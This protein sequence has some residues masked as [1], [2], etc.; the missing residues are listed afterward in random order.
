MLPTISIIG[1]PNVGKS[2]FFNALTKTRDALVA[3]ESGLTRDRKFGR[4]SVGDRDY[5]V[6]DTGGI[7]I[8]DDVIVSHITQQALLAIEESDAIFFVVDGR[9]GLTPV[10]EKL[11]QQIRKF[12]IPVYLVIN[13]SEGIQAEIISAEFLGLGLETYTISA[14]HRSGIYELME[15]VL[16][17]FPDSE[18]IEIDK[19]NRI[20]VAILGRPNVGKSTLVN[21]ILGYE[22]VIAFD[23][24]GTTRDSIFIPFEREGKSY[25]L[26]DTAGVRRR[27]KVHETIEKFSVI[28]A[29]QAIESANV[30]VMLLDANE[31]MTDQDANL[32]G[33][34]LDSGRA[35]IIAVNKWD[36]LDAS[37]REQVRYNL[38]RKLHFIDFATTHFIS[39]LHGKGIQTLFKSI[40]SA[41][42]AAN[43]ETSTSKLNY[44]L[45]AAISKHEPPIV[46]GRRIKL[47]YIHQAGTNPPLFIIHGNQVSSLSGTYKRYLINVLREQLQLKGTPIHLSFKQGDNPF[48]GRKTSLTPRQR[49]KKVRLM[50]HVK[51]K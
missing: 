23:K 33:N 20:K 37:K 39:A 24:P 15:P 10:D 28:K 30:V 6:I 45:E 29:L 38:N 26:I 16:A 42:L 17:S 35:L 2:T 5:W 51:K 3:D 9:A 8:D 7:G 31:G 21:R 44:I 40:N 49:K 11:A 36:D 43:K 32:L 50:K 18:K 14:A 12:N 47:R 41:W 1:R 48:A 19:D 22:R 34:V 27:A 4:G 25:T 13:K 46:R